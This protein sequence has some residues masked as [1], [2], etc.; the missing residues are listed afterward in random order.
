MP[1][2]IFLNHDGIIVDKIIGFYNAEDYLRKITNIFNGTDTFLSLKNDYIS[3]KNNME[4]LSKLANKCE[5]NFDLKLCT[6]IYSDILL[7]DENL[8]DS[9]ILFKSKLFFAKINLDNNNSSSIL[10]LI[11]ETNDL[12]S[13]KATYE[14]LIHYYQINSQSD[15]EANAYKTFSDRISTDPDVL[16]GY[17]WRMSELKMNLNDALDKVTI[18]VD[19]TANDPLKQANII[20]TKAE[21]L[22]VMGRYVDAIETINLAIDINSESNYFRNQKIKFQNSLKE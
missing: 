18:A 20:D 11:K 5:Y 21:I 3:G 4:V 12:E 7:I 6:D 22:W 19:L 2:L 16:N 14:T 9:K 15:N 17:A 10:K 8:I 1:T 13:L